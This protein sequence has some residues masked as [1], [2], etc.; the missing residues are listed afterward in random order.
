MTCHAQDQS[1]VPTFRRIADEYAAKLR[2]EKRSEATMAKFEW[3]LRF[4]NAAFA[5]EAIRQIPAPR[6]GEC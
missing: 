2:R 4:A 6:F 1:N 3:L 5:D